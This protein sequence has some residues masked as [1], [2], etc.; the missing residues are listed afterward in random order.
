MKVKAIQREF[1]RGKKSGREGKADVSFHILDHSNQR[2]S[3]TSF[4]AHRTL[5][6]EAVEKEIGTA[7]HK[8]LDQSKLYRQWIG[9]LSIKA[10]Q[11]NFRKQSKSGTS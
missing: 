10:S 9:S 7:L 1:Q 2:P 8:I 5:T 3:G 6:N 11:N 4:E